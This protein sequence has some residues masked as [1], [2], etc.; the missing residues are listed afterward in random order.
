MKA[1]FLHWDDFVSPEMCMCNWAVNNLMHGILTHEIFGAKLSFSCMEISFPRME[2]SYPDIF[3]CAVFMPLFFHALHLSHWSFPRSV[4]RLHY[5]S[6]LR[7]GYDLENTP[8]LVVLES[9]LQEM[10]FKILPFPQ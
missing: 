4:W 9:I 5:N 7:T 10:F 3:M 2:I 6:A 1:K 8:T